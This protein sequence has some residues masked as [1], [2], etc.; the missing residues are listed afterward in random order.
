MR[1]EPTINLLDISFNTNFARDIIQEKQGSAVQLLYQMCI[2]LTNKQKRQLTGAAMETMRPAGAVKLE[3][4]ESQIYRNV[5]L[6]KE[7]HFFEIF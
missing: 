4:F 2:A 5:R 6:I 1:L 3:L 7:S